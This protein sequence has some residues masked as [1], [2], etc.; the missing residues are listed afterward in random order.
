MI[1]A[2]PAVLEEDDPTRAAANVLH[3]NVGNKFTAEGSYDT[4]ANPQPENPNWADVSCS[5][6]GAGAS[7]PTAVMDGVTYNL[8]T[9]TYQKPL[10]AGETT[11]AASIVGFYLDKGI[12]CEYVKQ[13][14][15]TDKL[16]YTFNGRQIGYDLSSG[17]E[18]PVFAQ[19]V[20]AAGFA[21][22]E[23]AFTAAALPDN[24]WTT[25]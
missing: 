17:V 21:S 8:Y 3:W 24:P 4:T 11:S 14:D 9:F 13:M 7:I 25:T 15:G 6:E 19:A 5:W 18:I 10:A 16:V 22:A 2:I 12:D 20:Q 1:V 23:A